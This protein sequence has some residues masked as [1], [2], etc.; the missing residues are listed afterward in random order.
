MCTGSEPQHLHGSSPPR[1]RL[2]R[3]GSG[4]ILG[5]AS[6]TLLDRRIESLSS[7]TDPEEP[8]VSGAEGVALVGG[9]VTEVAEGKHHKREKLMGLIL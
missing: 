3:G 1:K 9:L 2:R 5:G 6:G 8:T 4:V 7:C